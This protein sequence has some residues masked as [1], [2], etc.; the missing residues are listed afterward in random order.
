VAF[1]ALLELA[2]GME[3]HPASVDASSISNA[4][5]II[6]AD[7]LSSEIGIPISHLDVPHNK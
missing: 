6:Q 3:A 7:F 1:S 4:P 5:P 2:N